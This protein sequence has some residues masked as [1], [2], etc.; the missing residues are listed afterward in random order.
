MLAGCTGTR[1]P[2]SCT[3]DGCPPPGTSNSPT[4]SGVTDPPLPIPDGSN[5]TVQFQDCHGG[6]A[7][8]EVPYDAVRQVVPPPFSV[9]GLTPD[10][11]SIVIQVLNCP[12]AV[13]NSSVL[14]G[15]HYMSVGATVQ[16]KDPSWRT[17]G[18]HRFLLNAFASS[19]LAEALTSEG[20]PVSA[21]T[22]ERTVAPGSGGPAIHVWKVASTACE[23]T[24]SLEAANERSNEASGEF[25]EWIGNGPFFRIEEQHRYT[26][27]KV[28]AAGGAAITG[29]C[30]AQKATQGAAAYVSQLVHEKNI[31]WTLSQDQYL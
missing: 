21:A 24:L 28:V 4:P 15:A 22:F 23:V 17:P 19:L 9:L 31:T 13:V 29:Y 12:R 1:D 30:A 20:V 2:P 27:D 3:G 7:G 10:T 11:A 16:P 14:S 25:P 5:Q 8:L 6:H 26:G 18:V